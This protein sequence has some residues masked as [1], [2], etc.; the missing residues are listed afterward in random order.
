MS[1]NLTINKHKRKL[2]E[3]FVRLI[4]EQLCFI[5]LQFQAKADSQ[6]FLKK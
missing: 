2:S 6:Q 4:Y 3:S 5:N 1:F